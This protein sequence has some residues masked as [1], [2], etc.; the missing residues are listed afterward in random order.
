MLP[1]LFPAESAA[2]DRASRERGV[3]VEALMENAGRAVARA[4]ARVA[5]GR[6]GRRAVVV[7]G[8]GNNGGDGLVAARHLSRW[9]M[10]VSV[11]LAAD[12]AEFRGPAATNLERLGETL[13]RVEPFSRARLSRELDRAHVAIDSI[14]G[15]G[16][17]GRPEG[18]FA[19][20]IELINAASP[21]VVAVDVPSGVSG[22]TGTVEGIAVSAHVTVTFGG[23]KP[24][25]LLHP[26]AGLAGRVLV[27][28][29]GFPPGLVRGDLWAVEEADVR[30]MLPS[31]PADAHKRSSGVVLVIGGSRGMPGAAILMARAAYRAGAGLVTVA[32][33]EGI[34]PVVQ[35][36]AVEATA[37]PL[38]Q[39][40]EGTVA[41]AA[42]DLVAERLESFDAVALGPGLSTQDETAGFGR[43]LVRAS[44]VPLVVDA[45][46]LN[47]FAGRAGELADRRAEAVLTPHAGELA[48]LAGVSSPEAAADRIGHAR[49]LA[50]ETG[51]V[52]LAKGNP[53]VV[54]APGGEA[55]LNPTGGPALATG[56]TGDVLTGAI[57]ALLARGLPGLDAATAAA[58]VHGLAGDMAGQDLGAGTT[59]SDV[60]A[61]LPVAFRRLGG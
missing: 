38:P 40:G 33:P 60:L 7:C 9:G 3:P 56:G 22:E 25:L 8:K 16:F 46:A 51:A 12:S 10:G 55:R 54:A 57:A 15:T 4:A 19:Q 45:D 34:L 20:A 23:L 53:T 11:V 59:A 28:D 39:T 31:R 5:G 26:G 30:A 24:G 43:G 58:Y 50:A 44:P 17:R 41:R 21:P 14:F 29:I 18:S 1:V 2:L 49:K 36:A 6:Y 35:S 37:L 27:A 48:R 32:V 42:L 13:A 47:A 61:R 52:V